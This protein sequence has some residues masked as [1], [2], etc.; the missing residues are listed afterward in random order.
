KDFVDLF[1]ILRESAFGLDYLIGRAKEKEAA[2]DQE[3]AV[4]EFAT[5]LLAVED[6]HLHEIRMIKALNVEE[7]RSFL[8]PRAEALIRSLR[9]VGR[10]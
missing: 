4:L 5:K 6:L 3:D 9:P 7:L 10:T 2:F 1:F 8:I